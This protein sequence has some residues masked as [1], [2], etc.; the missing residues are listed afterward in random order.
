[1]S[2]WL[3]ILAALLLLIGLIGS[4][5]SQWSNQQFPVKFE[6]DFMRQN[7]G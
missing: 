4:R 3:W 1:V 6:D 7:N 2:K 5:E